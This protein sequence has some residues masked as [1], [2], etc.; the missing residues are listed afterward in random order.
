MYQPAL[1]NAES[2]SLFYYSKFPTL[3]SRHT[4]IAST[5]YAHIELAQ[6]ARLQQLTQSPS[7]LKFSPSTDALVTKYVLKNLAGVKT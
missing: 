7:I 4:R 6:C 2:L 3:S 5:L 1:F